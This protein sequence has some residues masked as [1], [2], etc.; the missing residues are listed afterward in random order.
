MPATFT[1][2]KDSG[3]PCIIDLFGGAATYPC[4]LAALFPLG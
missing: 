1:V 3:A 2:D 4:L